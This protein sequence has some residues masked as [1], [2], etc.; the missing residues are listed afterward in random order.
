MYT[1]ISSNMWGGRWNLVKV[2]ELVLKL[3]WQKKVIFYLGSIFIC[4]SLGMGGST[5]ED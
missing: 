5:K 3:P 1:Y 2:R 4:V